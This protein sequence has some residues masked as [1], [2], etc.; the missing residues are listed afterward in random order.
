M[1]VKITGIEQV[2]AI[3]RAIAP[4]EARNLLNTTVLD[5]AKQ[6]SAEAKT[7][8]PDDPATAEWAGDSFTQKR[9]RA[10][11]NKVL[12]SAM[13]KKAKGSRSFIWRFHEFGTGPDHVERAMYLRSLQKMRGEMMAVYLSTFGRKLEA[14]LKRLRKARG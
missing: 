1:T 13:V 12:A 11:R 2:N 5:M 6:L 3:L 8:M 7:H 4:N 14:R 10:P 9:E